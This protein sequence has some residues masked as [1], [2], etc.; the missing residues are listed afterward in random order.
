MSACRQAASCGVG[1]CWVFVFTYFCLLAAPK[2]SQPPAPPM[3][4]I[5]TV[6]NQ[7]VLR[8][9]GRRRKLMSRMPFTATTTTA[10]RLQ[11]ILIY[12]TGP[13]SLHRSVLQP[14]FHLPR[15][16]WTLVTE[17]GHCASRLSGTHLNQM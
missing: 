12:I 9:P 15:C 5:H 8:G 14:G 1:V 6:P 10:I 13:P 4:P 7:A 2:Q 16:S 17:A 11:S 3:V